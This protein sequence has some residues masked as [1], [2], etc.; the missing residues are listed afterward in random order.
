MY[1]INYHERMKRLPRFHEKRGTTKAGKEWVAY[2]YVV[3]A[4]GKTKWTALGN[5]KSAA[6]RKWAELE[7]KPAPTEAGTFNAVADEYM[8]WAEAEVVNGDLAPR[9]IEDRKKYLK[10]M[11]PVFGIHP[12]S[13]IKSSH[14]V[15]YID[16]RSSKHSAGQEMRFLSAMWNWA[17]ARDIVATVNPVTGIKLPGT[18][19]R[20]IEVRAQDYWLVHGCGDQMVKDVMELAARLG[21]RPQEVFG[22]TWGKIDLSAP[23]SVKVWMNKTTGFKVVIAD[24]ELEG[25]IQRLRGDHAKPKGNVLVDEDGAPLNPQGA[26]RYRFSLARAAAKKKAAEAGVEHQDF[27]LRDLRPMAGLAM[28]DAEGMDAARRLLGHT[29]ERMTAHYTTKR[30]GFVSKSAT[31]KPDEVRSTS[32]PSQK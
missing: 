6:L 14:V 30:R 21:T 29:T 25:L 23:I 15:K 7:A 22:L 20:L 13:A 27:Q 3:K 2:Y 9:T 28:L 11:R 4:E 24:A 26:F 18:G 19:N 10:V 1:H 8:K 5:N 31:L 17:K 12:F 32:N 16:N